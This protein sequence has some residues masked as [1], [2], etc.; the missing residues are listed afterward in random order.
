[1]ANGSLLGLLPRA[2][3]EAALEAAAGEGLKPLRLAVALGGGEPEYRFDFLPAVRRELGLPDEGRARRWWWAAVGVLALINLVVLFGRDIVSV[4]RLRQAVDAQRPGVGAVMGVRRRVE[5]QER[6]RRA[7]I[8]RGERGDPLPVLAA[9][10][11][12]LP[13]T[14]WVQ[15]LEWNGQQARIVGF[16]SG[17]TDLLAVLRASPAFVGARAA[18]TATA[19]KTGAGQPFDVTVDVGKKTH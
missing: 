11:A 19:A 9:L 2:T 8:E 15:R 3:A 17:D 16:K 13:P 5:A 14:A 7:L 10:T 18:A 6:A 1:M 12:A 4:D